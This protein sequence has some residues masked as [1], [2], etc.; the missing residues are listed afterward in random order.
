MLTRMQWTAG[1]LCAVFCLSVSAQNENETVRPA[2]N[3]V[4]S[5]EPS[6]GNPR[7]SE[8]DFIQL[9]DGRILRVGFHA[10]MAVPGLSRMKSLC[11]MR[12]R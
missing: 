11:Q 6:A 2:A 12:G 4:L 8:G 1:L 9:R 5:L 3:L 10:I 7:N